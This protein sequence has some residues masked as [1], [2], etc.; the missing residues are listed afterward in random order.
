MVFIFCSKYWAVSLRVPFYYK[1]I[2][3]LLSQWSTLC[4]DLVSFT[5]ELFKDARFLTLDGI[6]LFATCK[7]RRIFTM[8]T[9]PTGVSDDGNAVGHIYKRLMSKL[10]FISLP[11][12]TGPHKIHICLS[13][14]NIAFVLSIYW[15][16]MSSF[17]VKITLNISSYWRNI[18]E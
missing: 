13:L 17:P 12:L 2:P 3:F 16:K 15:L 11:Y 10:N 4:I 14:K 18:I 1:I 6:T 5:G 7:V 8:K 9:E